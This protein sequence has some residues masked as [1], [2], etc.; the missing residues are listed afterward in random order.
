MEHTVPILELELETMTPGGEALARHEGMVIF[1][2]FGVPGE[3]VQARITLQKKRFARAEIVDILRAAPHRVEPV[4]RYFGICGGCQWQQIEYGAQLLYKE[5]I[6][7]EQFTRI[8]RFADAQVLPCIPSPSPYGYRNRARLARSPRNRPGYRAAQSHAVV[9]VDDCPILEA[10]LNQRLHEISRIGLPPGDGDWELRPDASTLR[11]GDFRY[12]VS[13]DSFFQVNTLIA[14]RL[15]DEVLAQLD[16]RGNERVLDLYCGVGLF[17]LPLSLRAAHITGVEFSS[18]ATAD[19]AANL[20]ALRADHPHMAETTILTAAVEEALA[21]P[22]IADGRWDAVIV[23][24]PRAGVDRGA[25]ERILA[26]RPPQIVYVSCDPATLARDA[27]ILADGGY[28][29]G[30]IQ[31]LDMFPQTHH[32][33]SVARLTKFL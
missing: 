15:V 9:E 11:V 8:G 2:P 32:V 26:L 13:P 22:Q 6:V 17:T 3:R 33:E 5:A 16:L 18:S 24:P 30:P 29:L 20:A 23:D 25:L 21:R 27:R 7:A 1:V 14:A 28:V 10:D 12:T 31:P 4:C 19:A